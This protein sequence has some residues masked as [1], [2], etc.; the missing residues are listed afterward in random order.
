MHCRHCLSQHK[1]CIL[2]SLWGRFEQ[3][4]LGGPVA[5]TAGAPTV[6][7]A[8]PVALAVPMV[9]PIIGTNTYQRVQT[10]FEYMH[11]SVDFH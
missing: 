8:V 6:V 3:E 5:V 11:K 7:E 2:V 4:V 10:I 1:F 9:R